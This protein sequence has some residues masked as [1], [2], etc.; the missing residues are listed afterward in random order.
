MLKN[1]KPQDTS[2]FDNRNKL[3]IWLNKK[4]PFE[5]SN[6]YINNKKFIYFNPEWLPS[7]R[8][9]NKISNRIVRKYLKN[10]YK[11]VKKS[12]LLKNKLKSELPSL[13]LNKKIKKTNNQLLNEAKK[14]SKIKENILKKDKEHNKN[15]NILKAQ[16]KTKKEI[17]KI[18]NEYK[19]KVH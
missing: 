13:N 18:I 9:N 5:S 7:S 19:T 1:E 14:D 3:A 10:K 4:N 11:T 8:K 16:G 17:L 15:I 2:A 6:D 12:G